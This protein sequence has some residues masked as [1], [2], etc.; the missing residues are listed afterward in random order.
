M[1]GTK[2]TV[3]PAFDLLKEYLDESFDLQTTSEVCRVP[4]Q[5]IQSLA[6]QLSQNKGASLLAAGMGPN[7]YFNNDL[8]GR[9]HF[10]VAALTD[11]IGHIGGNVG[12][13]AGNY[14]GSLFQAM[15]QWILENPFDIEPDLTKPARVKKYYKAESA[16]YW[17]YGERPLRAV[18]TGDDIHEGESITGKSHMPTPTKLIWFGNSNSLLGNAKWSFDVVKNTLPRQDAIFCNEWHWTSSCEYADMVFPADSWAEFK[19]PDMT[20][21]CTNPFLLA[22]PTTPLERIH[23]SRSDYEILALTAAALGKLVRR[24]AHGRVLE[25]RPRR[26]PVA[27]PAADPRRLERNPRNECSRTCMRRRRRARRS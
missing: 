14:R 22:F 6:R 25:G 15:P 5:A 13:Y 16:H 19:L 10:L 8:F 17:N 4:P 1:D 23:D 24:A 18:K 9:V 12:S 26:R 27:V 3:R 7:H 11:N 2:V 20:A 21:S